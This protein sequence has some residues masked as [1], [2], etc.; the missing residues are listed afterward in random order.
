MVEALIKSG[1][2]IR[3]ENIFEEVKKKAAGFDK[4]IG[5]HGKAQTIHS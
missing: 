4:K 3:L 1:A 2:D 5:P